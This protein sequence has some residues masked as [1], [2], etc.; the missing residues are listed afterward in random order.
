MYKTYTYDKPKKKLQNY[1][2]LENSEVYNENYE[3]PIY[4]DT[5]AKAKKKR[6][7]EKQLEEENKSLP[8]Y[9]HKFAISPN[10][11]DGN[12]V[13]FLSI[14]FSGTIH[15]DYEIDTPKGS[16]EKSDD[17]KEPEHNFLGFEFERDY[18]K[19]QIAI[20]ANSKS[21]TLIDLGSGITVEVGASF[22]QVDSE[23]KFSKPKLELEAK[24]RL[25]A[26]S[27]DGPVKQMITQIYG[28]D[29]FKKGSVVDIVAKIEI[30]TTQASKELLEFVS[31]HKRQA[32]AL[33]EEAKNLKK[34]AKELKKVRE[35][36]LD[37]FV[38]DEINDYKKRNGKM[39]SKGN[40]KRYI[41]KFYRTETNQKFQKQIRKFRRRVSGIEDEL[42]QTQKI[43][44]KRLRKVTGIFDGPIIRGTLSVVGRILAIVGT[45]LNVIGAI[46]VAWQLA[47][48][49]MRYGVQFGFNPLAILGLDKKGPGYDNPPIF[50][51]GDSEDVEADELVHNDPFNFI[52]ESGDKKNESSVNGK[53]DDEGGKGDSPDRTIK[54]GKSGASNSKS[55]TDEETKKGSGTQQSNESP[56]K[57]IR[58]SEQKDDVKASD[59]KKLELL[60]SEEGNTLDEGKTNIAKNI[61]I[62]ELKNP[63]N[64]EGSNVKVD[65][66]FYAVARGKLRLY[67]FKDVKTIL[68]TN[69]DGEKVYEIAKSITYKFSG[70]IKVC[71]EQGNKY[72]NK[73]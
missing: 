73:K 34:Q 1:S 68:R 31:K 24:G 16:I 42:K 45:I 72:K 32:K 19:D 23:G 29:L 25:S 6:D 57:N 66:Y 17:N 27:E 50:V 11:P 36:A 71:L 47:K 67:H 18:V 70:G 5:Y 43:L 59:I 62:V 37:N 2:E 56:A 22:F 10:I 69:L 8:K 60:Y 46:I 61:R 38:K 51:K 65:I 33:E 41:E 7:K 52:H 58:V 48:D 49:I 28:H 63:T 14:N 15:S 3:H 12:K 21:A 64:K 4:Q 54:E 26:S 40:V 30:D 44:R 55:E 35:K 20:A 13:N 39:P 9:K 53:R